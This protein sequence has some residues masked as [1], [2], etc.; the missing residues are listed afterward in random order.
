MTSRTIRQLVTRPQAVSLPPGATVAE[1]CRV[2]RDH[3]IGAVLVM[4]Q[5]DLQGIFTERDAVYR[6]LAEGLDPGQTRLDQVMTRELVTLEPETAAVDA[7]RLMSQ[8]GFR[9][10]PIVEAGRVQGV[11][12]L[13]DF[14]GAELQQ[15][16]R[17]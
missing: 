2:M 6:V 7:L 8:I 4:D 9:H 16:D 11:I 1:A 15:V 17:P 10:L 12:S 5:D 3:R 13:R 14:V